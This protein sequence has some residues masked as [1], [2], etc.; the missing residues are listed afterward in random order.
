L[1]FKPFTDDVREAPSLELI[2]AL[3]D[4][5][6]EIVT[7]DPQVGAD[8]TKH[9]RSVVRFADNPVECAFGAQAIVLMTEWPEIVDA[10]WGQIAQIVKEPR[11]LFDGRNAL[12]PLQMRSLGFDY[13]GV[14][15]RWAHASGINAAPVLG[16]VGD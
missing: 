3:A 15:R 1:S 9:L 16:R 11:F 7:Y 12:D 14:G 2:D 13:L 6:V 10:N 5:G 4:E 8:S